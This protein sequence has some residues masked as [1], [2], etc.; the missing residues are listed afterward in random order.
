MPLFHCILKDISKFQFDLDAVD[1]KPFC[2]CVT[3]NSQLFFIVYLYFILAS[4]PIKSGVLNNVPG[5][6]FF[7]ASDPTKDHSLVFPF[8][9]LSLN[10]YIGIFPFYNP[11]TESI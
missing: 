3:A 5:I 2:V 9:I 11:A 1:K 6:A 8:R 10:L 4:V 7:F